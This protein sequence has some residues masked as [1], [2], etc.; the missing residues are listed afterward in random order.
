MRHGRQYFDAAVEAC[1][2]LG[3]RGVLL[4]AGGEQI[5]EKLPASIC[6]AGYAPFSE[7][8]PRAACVVHHGGLGTSAQGLR[9]GVPQ[10]VMPLAY[11]QADNA[12]RMRRLGVASILYP[13]RFTGRAVAKRLGPLLADDR[14]K[15]SAKEVAGRLRGPDGATVAATLIEELVGRDGPRPVERPEVPPVARR[16]RVP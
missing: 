8:F 11:D 13:K 2:I 6:H 15:Q 4:G 16:S 14:A 9:A 5:P 7:V 12:V 1:G 10:L 3:V